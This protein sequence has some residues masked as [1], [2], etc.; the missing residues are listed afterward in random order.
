MIIR[1]ACTTLIISA[2]FVNNKY[3]VF[4]DNHDI[5]PGAAR[6]E[7]YVPLLAGKRAGIVANN[8][9]LINSTNIVDSLKNLGINIVKIF[10]P[11]HGFLGT[12]EAGEL[13]SDSVSSKDN[14]SIISL[15]SDKKKPAAGDLQNID[16]MV[17]DIQDV[18]VRFYTY[19]STMHYV[20]EAC[21]EEKIP[22]IIL[23]RP[24]PNGF[25]VDGPVLQKQYRSFTG[26]HPVPVVYGMTI[27]E[28]AGMIN[29][30]KWLNG[31]VQCELEIVLCENYSHGYYY[32]LP[33]SPS[34]NLQN[35]RSVYLYPSL[36]LFE[37]TVMNVGRGTDF[38]FQVYGH[39]A[40]KDKEFFYMPRKTAETKNPRHRNMKC[41]GVDLRNRDIESIRSEKQINL[42]YI[43]DAYKKMDKPENFF[44]DYF[45]YLAGNGILK[46]QII[47]GLTDGQIRSSWHDDLTDFKTIRKKY[48]L[49]PDFE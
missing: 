19:I 18:G 17:F 33:A 16:I 37:G 30:E 8:I 42:S 40:Y 26:M 13:I 5:K 10:A 49:Y 47:D 46:K 34:P 14:V 15:Y 12:A 27:G 7:E 25:Y 31:G 41:Y 23:D 32:E 45:N 24:N 22:L 4:S 29:G 6:T 1:L 9:S 35:M 20:M 39:P 28:Y 11:E 21:A 2:L 48:L 43:I 3:P 38:P 44:T 36:C